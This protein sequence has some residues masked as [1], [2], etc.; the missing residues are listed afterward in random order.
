MYG[1]QT[2]LTSHSSDPF[3]VQRAPTWAGFNEKLQHF[4]R[5]NDTDQ[6]TFID[7]LSV[8]SFYFILYARLFIGIR[9]VRFNI[10]EKII[11]TVAMFSCWNVIGNQVDLCVCVHLMFYLF[12]SAIDRDISAITFLEICAVFLTV[13]CLSPQHWRVSLYY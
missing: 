5:T 8:F 2:K 3:Y 10:T 9:V 11:Y 12:R 13:Q 1:N 6:R 4:S 7:A